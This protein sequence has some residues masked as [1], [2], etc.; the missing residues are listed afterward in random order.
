MPGRSMEI[1]GQIG[2]KVASHMLPTRS[3]PGAATPCYARVHSATDRGSEA[4]SV[5]HPGAPH[6]SRS[7]SYSLMQGPLFAAA[8]LVLP[9]S[10]LF[11]DSMTNAI[12][13]PVAARTENVTL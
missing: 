8:Q 11:E 12:L 7:L 1:T 3:C 2:R 6:R 9:E 5:S 13:I 4:A 10:E